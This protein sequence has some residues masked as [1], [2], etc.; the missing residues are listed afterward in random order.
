MHG[1]VRSHYI[2]IR[3]FCILVLGVMATAAALNGSCFLDTETNLCE[4]SGRRCAPGQV[5]AAFQDACIPIDGCGDNIINRARGEVCDDGNISNGDGCSSDCTTNVLCGNGVIDP[6]EEC[7]ADADS[8]ACDGDCTFIMCGDSHVNMESG[9]GCDTGEGNPNTPECNG[10]LCTKSDCGDSYYNPISGEACDTGGDSQAC[11]GNGNGD[12][13]NNIDSKCQIP[14]CGDGYAN[15]KFTLPGSTLTEACDTGGDSQ[16]CNGDGNNNPANNT[17]SK[18]QV[19]KCGDGYLNTKHANAANQIEQCDSGMADTPTCNGNNNNSGKGSCRF[20]ACGDG[21]FNPMSVNAVSQLEQCDI[22]TTGPGTGTA[23]CNG[24]NGGVGSCR[25]PECGD[26]YF[27]PA[28]K[29]D[30]DVFEGCDNGPNDTSACNGNNAGRASCQTVTCGDGYLNTTAGEECG[31]SNASCPQ[32]KSCNS[33][34]KC[35]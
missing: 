13:T 7:D 19:A 20:A 10:R 2:H 9:E 17:S 21:Y 3:G 18:C 12:S 6:N 29:T 31:E 35:V 28:S 24:N 22:G 4:A 32:G 14:K 26:G 25:T 34:C 8:P 1:V 5:C 16:T 23:A 30:A 11:N 27:N 33:R 15:T